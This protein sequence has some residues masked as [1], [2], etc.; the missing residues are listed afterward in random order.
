MVKECHF[1]VAFDYSTNMGGVD[2]K[3]KMLQPYLLECKKSNKLFIK[4]FKGFL[5]SET[6]LYFVWA[7]ASNQTL[8]YVSLSMALIK[9]CIESHGPAVL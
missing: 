5:P 8:G 7:T 9:G 6:Q 4:I 2:L 3:V 1:K